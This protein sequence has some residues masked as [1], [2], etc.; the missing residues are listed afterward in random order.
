MSCAL[1][2]RSVIRNRRDSILLVP[3]GLISVAFVL[4]TINDPMESGQIGA[5]V[6]VWLLGAL[7]VVGGAWLVIRAFRWGV[8]VDHK[9][10][11]VVNLFRTHRLPL[12]SVT[13]V[14]IGD[15]PFFNLPA[16]TVVAEGRRPI[17]ASALSASPL[18]TVIHSERVAKFQVNLTRLVQEYRT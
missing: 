9:H 4:F 3:L 2:D 10:V 15:I 18:E 17:V 5:V 12:G 13:D 6:A 1:P 16:V 8:W 7:M 11:T 14:T